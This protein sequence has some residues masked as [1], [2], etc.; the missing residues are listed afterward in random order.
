MKKTIIFP[1]LLTLIFLTTACQA[2]V[3]ESATATTIPTSTPVAFVT[4]TLPVTNTPQAS[5]TAS[6]APSATPIPPVIGQTTSQVNARDTPSEGGQQVGTIEIFAEVEIVGTDPA[7]KWWLILL[8]ESATGKG[9]ISAEFVQV[10]NTSG[11]PVVSIESTNAPQA[12]ITETSSSSSTGEAVA[13]SAPTLSLATAPADGDSAQNPA[14]IHTLSKVDFPYFEYS[15][16]LSAPEGDGD[17][18][19]QFSLAGDAGQEKI[20]AV[21]VDNTG[22]GRLNLELMQNGVLLQSWEKLD[23]SRHQLQLYLYV[24]APYSLHF[25]PA[26]REMPTYNSYKVSV[27]LTK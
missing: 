6:P 14:L 9:W 1:L 20:V 11:V 24:G 2:E 17:D 7:K 15:S 12:S 25:S 18:W 23:F 8:S 10:E 22:S 5:A 4:A 21:V 13:T 26:S 16:E 19:V 27:Q 3:T